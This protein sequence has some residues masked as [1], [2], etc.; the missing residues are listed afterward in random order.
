MNVKGETGIDARRCDRMRLPDGAQRIICP[1]H[2][3]QKK[4][5]YVSPHRA[6][7]GK[8]DQV[9][10]SAPIAATPKLISLT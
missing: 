10:S 9:E 3:F 6:G 8:I 7:M 1:A 4:R 5:G 2:E